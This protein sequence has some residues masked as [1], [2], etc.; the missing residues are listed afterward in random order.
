M[1]MQKYYAWPVRL[2]SALIISLLLFGIYPQ[3]AFSSCEWEQSQVRRAIAK[4]E[5]YMSEQMILDSCRELEDAKSERQDR[6]TY[7]SAPSSY[8]SSSDSPSYSSSDD[9]G[10]PLFWILLGTVAGI[11]VYF[12]GKHK[13]AQQ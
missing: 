8:R 10:I 3:K 6:S 13:S 4:G 7:R 5:S 1:S 9:E 2:C 11:G 12:K